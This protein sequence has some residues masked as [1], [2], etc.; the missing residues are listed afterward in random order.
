M[1]VKT[2]ENTKQGNKFQIRCIRDIIIGKESRGQDATFERDLLKA[3]S[4]YEG[5][6][7]ALEALPPALSAKSRALRR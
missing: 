5:W 7:S 2:E 6:E 1:N 4:K 3:W